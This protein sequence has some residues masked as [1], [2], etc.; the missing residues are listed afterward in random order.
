MYLH[1]KSLSA[2]TLV[3]SFLFTTPLLAAGLSTNNDVVVTKGGQIVRSSMGTCVRTKWSHGS[4]VCAQPPIQTAQEPVI[5]ARPRVTFSQEERTVYFEFNKSDLTTHT[6]NKLDALSEKLKYADNISSTEI[7]GFADRIGSIEDNQQL[8]MRRA[9]SVKD[10]LASRGYLE[11]RVAAVRGYGEAQP[12]SNCG[13]DMNR[14]KTI[15]CLS[16]DRR[17]EID[18]RYTE[19]RPITRN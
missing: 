10:Y 5:H 17:V 6:R 7:V 19:T 4:D 9:H 18:V 12:I 1:Y 14:T 15:S 11:T 3:T 8:S 13:T 16:P 2:I